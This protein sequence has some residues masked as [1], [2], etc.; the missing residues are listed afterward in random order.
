[1]K[2]LYG[3]ITRSA[4]TSL[5]YVTF[6]MTPSTSTSIR[7]KVSDRLFHDRHLLSDISED[8]QLGRELQIGKVPERRH[9]LS[10]TPPH[11]FSRD[12]DW[13]WKWFQTAKGLLNGIAHSLNEW[14]SPR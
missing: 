14:I 9:K 13:S 10:R 11:H 12:T 2:S 3:S 5:S 7:Q 8:G 6:S 4:V 1:M